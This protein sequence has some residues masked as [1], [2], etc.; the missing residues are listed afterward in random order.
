MI[1]QT[2]SHYHIVEKLGGGGMG[3]VYKAEDTTLGR[4]VALKFLP[5]ELAGDA[6]MMERFRREARLASA[7]NHPNICTIYEI[8]QQDGH[9]FIAMELL[10]GQTLSSLIANKPLSIN[11]V[12][13]LGIQVTD[14][15]DVAHSAGIIHRDIKPANIFVTTK[16]QAKVLDFGLAISAQR[17]RVGAGANDATSLE[18]AADHLTAPGTTIGTV[19]YMSPEQALGEE[20][21]ARTDLFSLG[22]VIYEMA[23]GKTPFA[24]GS[25]AEVFAALLREN[26]PPVSTVNPAMPKR[27]DFIVARLLA[28]DP[29][30][31]YATAEQLQE[32]LEGLGAQSGKAML[33]SE[34]G[35]KWPWAI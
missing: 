6:D 15:L 5:E 33:A 26:P 29:A 28:K 14:A 10:Q 17:R 4:L 34:S 9:Y 7:L 32:A 25:T 12:V 3:V 23:T 31:R 24:G 1:G 22:T 13:D 11:R 19:A 30:R 16:G 18:S 27:L 8:G 35:R 2:I 21:D 20:L